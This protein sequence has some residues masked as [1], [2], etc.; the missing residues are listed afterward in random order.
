[1]TIHSEVI[2]KVC[3][4]LAAGDAAAASAI[5]RSEYPFIPVERARRRYSVYE[6]L[7][8]FWR[9]GFVDRFSGTRLVFPGTL[10]L[11]SLSLPDE[12]PYHSAWKMS[13]CH[14]MYWELFPTIDHVMP[15]ARG[16]RDEPSNTVTTSMLRNGAKANWTLA[17]LG[18]E[19]FSPGDPAEWDGLVAWFLRMVERE[20][21][22]LSDRYLREWH[23]AAIHLMAGGTQNGF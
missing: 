10:R 23:R 12:F 18:W 5:A 20:P 22:Q 2:A 1:M 3:T 11:L 9:D 13:E 8:V 7:L 21:A 16:G 14:A 15:L 17:E 6:S 4:A 19:V